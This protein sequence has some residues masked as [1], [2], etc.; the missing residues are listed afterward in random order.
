MLPQR[1]T[2]IQNPSLWLVSILLGIAV[3]QLLLLSQYSTDGFWTITL[4]FWGVAGYMLWE[5]LPTLQL[6]SSW[7]ATL[8]GG[9]L[10]GLSVGAAVSVTQY[11]SHQ[12]PLQILA[13]SGGG[14][15]CLLASGFAGLNQHRQFLGLLCFASFPEVF[16]R[17]LPIEMP[18]VTAKF[19]TFCLWYAGFKVSRE[20][21][22]IQLP[23]G[24]VFVFPDCSGIESM[25]YLWSLAVLISTFL[26]FSWRSQILLSLCGL[27]L[28][29]GIN[30]IR[31]SC[32]AVLVAANQNQGFAFWH[33]GTGSL[34]FSGVGAIL[35]SGISAWLYRMENRSDFQTEP[36]L[37]SEF[38]TLFQSSFK[39]IQNPNSGTQSSLVGEDEK[40][41]GLGFD[42]NTITQFEF[43]DNSDSTL[44]QEN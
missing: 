13:F 8:I 27:L 31:M 34:I 37:Q 39:S 6:R 18:L 2:L 40:L 41:Y 9:I 1:A 38:K 44:D 11:P 3:I 10:L 19:T 32:L 7:G 15:W 26:R 43:G 23:G 22:L 17:L 12:I 21:D 24:S 33:D 20:E 29:F 36:D 35:L 5:K 28:G 30:G 42:S 25:A 4:L 14:S 16:L